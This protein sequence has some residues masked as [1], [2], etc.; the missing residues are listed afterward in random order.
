MHIDHYLDNHDV[1]DDDD[2]DHK[3]ISK[4]DKAKKFINTVKIPVMFNLNQIIPLMQLS[5]IVDDVKN[6]ERLLVPL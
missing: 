6:N 2:I 3:T 1:G 4:K 5:V